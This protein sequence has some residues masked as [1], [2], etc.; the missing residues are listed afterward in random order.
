MNTKISLSK[1][2]PLILK[3]DLVDKGCINTIGKV[4]RCQCIKPDVYECALKFTSLNIMDKQKIREY[5]YEQL[6]DKSDRRHDFRTKSD[7]IINYSSPTKS[8]VKNYNSKGLCLI[9][10]R[11]F[12]KGEEILLTL[13]IPEEQKFHVY[14]K[15]VWC[16]SS[17][18]GRYKTGVK[19][20]HMDDDTRSR[21]MV[22]FQ[23]YITNNEKST[24]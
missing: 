22:F 10:K 16:V 12:K 20:C 21:V 1:G 24:K 2:M 17:T 13:S 6:K 9:T 14:C 11:A 8:T 23:S 7:I 19:F 15:V 18:S 4:V 5:V 3:F